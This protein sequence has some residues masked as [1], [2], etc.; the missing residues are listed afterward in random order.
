M[1]RS[2]LPVTWHWRRIIDFI[3]PPHC[4][5]CQTLGSW[6]CDACQASVR[7]VTP[8]T[9]AQCGRPSVP[10]GL[11]A[12]CRAS[13][14]TIESI[15][16]MA[17]FDGRLRQAIHT[18]KYR[19]VAA[20]AD[21]LGDALARFWLQSP[22]LADVI[23]PVPLHPDRQRERGYNQAALLAH[24]LG[25]AAGLPVRPNA[26]RRVRATAAQ[27]LLNAPDRKAN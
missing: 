10:S 24:R 12:D 3:F 23:V 9:C 5:G 1:A 18:F 16:S 17:L 13:P 15:R 25:R 6:W 22:V 27:M 11:C 4:G 21:P 26:L 2:A 8:P 14:L 7:G 19:R 20:L